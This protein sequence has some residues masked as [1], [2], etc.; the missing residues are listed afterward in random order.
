MDCG[1]SRYYSPARS[2]ARAT[3][4][5]S[6]ELGRGV[7]QSCS[8]AD[9]HGRISLPDSARLNAGIS[10]PKGFSA[11]RNAP[12]DVRLGP[13]LRSDA[14]IRGR[15]GPGPER[16]G[17]RARSAASGGHAALASCARFKG[18][19]ELSKPGGALVASSSSGASRNCTSPDCR[20][21]TAPGPTPSSGASR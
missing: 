11:L 6:L 12:E 9:G 17:Q 2:N 19:A 13:V 7:R 1:Q 10:D 21:R 3:A 8:D 16:R 15:Q 20:A 4:Q 14:T 5:S 18:G